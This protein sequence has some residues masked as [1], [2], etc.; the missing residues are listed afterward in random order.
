M[1]QKNRDFQMNVASAKI[2]Q[3]V[4]THISF[5][6]KLHDLSIEGM[7]KA[8]SVQFLEILQFVCAAT[9]LRF[10]T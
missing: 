10:Y 8:I 6:R 5:E 9:A 4:Q 7:L 2:N 1:L 3:N